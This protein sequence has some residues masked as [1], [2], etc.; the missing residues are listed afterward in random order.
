M[1]AKKAVEKI[2][3]FVAKPFETRAGDIRYTVQVMQAEN[4]NAVREYYRARG[5]DPDDVLL[6]IWNSAQSQYVRQSAKQIVRTALAEGKDVEE[7][8]ARHQERAPRMIIGSP[9][10]PRGGI[11]KK[12]V[13]EAGTAVL[14]RLAETGGRIDTAELVK[15][16]QEYG[17]DLSALK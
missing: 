5:L 16:A 10:G 11:T 13:N 2:V 17:I 9:R 15:L 3:G 6:R 1:S 12:K 4:L 7:A 14:R 8:I